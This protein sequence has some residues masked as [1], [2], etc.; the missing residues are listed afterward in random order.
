MTSMNQIDLGSV[1]VHK[2]VLA[3]IV[4]TALEEVD[5]VGLIKK[6]VWQQCAE[7]IGCE[8][9][10]GVTVEILPNHDVTIEVKVCV[11][12]GLHIPDVAMVIQDTVKKAIAKTVSIHLKEINVNIQ[13]IEK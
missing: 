5:G 9:V 8:E 12:Y 6:N 10:P 13:G 4:M 2:K 1:Q 11:R 7:F 3:Q